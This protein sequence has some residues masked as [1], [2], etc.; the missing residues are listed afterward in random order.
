[1]TGHSRLEK[2]KRK[3]STLLA[4][5]NIIMDGSKVVVLIRLNNE[6]GFIGAGFIEA[7][8]IEK[9]FIETGFIE[10]GFIE[11]GFI[12]KGFIETG[13]IEKGSPRQGSS[14]KGSSRQGSHAALSPCTTSIR[15]R[16]DK[17]L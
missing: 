12:E 15:K 9:G 13:F 1:M 6:T 4:V 14:R 3:E 8:F 16:E 7:G 2:T 11:T 5:V 17:G 10:K